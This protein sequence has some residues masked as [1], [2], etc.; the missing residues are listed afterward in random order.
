MTGQKKTYT[1]KRE[2]SPPI[3]YYKPTNKK[4]GGQE[5]KETHSLT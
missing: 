5:T 4:R 1:H 3:G 2:R